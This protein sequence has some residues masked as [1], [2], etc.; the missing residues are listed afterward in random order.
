MIKQIIITGMLVI[1]AFSL[2]YTAHNRSEAEIHAAFVEGQR[3]VTSY[4]ESCTLANAH[5]RLCSIPCSSPADCVQKNGTRE[6]Y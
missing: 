3:D 1:I 6:A 2:G 5:A 4:V